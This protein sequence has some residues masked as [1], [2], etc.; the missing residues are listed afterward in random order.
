MKVIMEFIRVPLE[1]E[2][3]DEI[4][5]IELRF[6]KIN[7]FRYTIHVAKK[8][9]FVF[10]VPSFALFVSIFFNRKNWFHF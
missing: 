2:A 10:F 5:S 3:N 4:K 7:I 6:K 8:F 9:H 1:K